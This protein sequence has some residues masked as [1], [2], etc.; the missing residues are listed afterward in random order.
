MNR[1]QP[2]ADHNTERLTAACVLSSVGGML[3]IYTYL[4][5]GKV[6]ANAVTGNMVLFGFHL[7]HQEW[8]YSSKY[9]L[10]IMS[11]ALGIFTAELLHLKVP[12]SRKISWHQSVI[13]LELCLLLLV[14]FIPYGEWDFAVNALISF[15]CAL[16]VQTF[17]RVRGFPFASTMCTGNLRSG[18]DALFRAWQERNRQEWHKA[19]HYYVVIV[20][21]IAGAT[22][23]AI[24]LHHYG[25]PVFLL[26]PLGLAAV[27]FL[28]AP[29]RH[30]R[31]HYH[32]HHH[33][34]SRPPR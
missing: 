29:I 4:C 14:Y 2:T 11:Y 16:Q 1:P 17:R 7:A 24:L 22:T 6:F 8:A 27:F 30:H 15:V 13:L 21:F 20:C 33:R 12:A 3:D 31:I 23:G 9:L 18:T 5:R 25:K 26:A 32:R 28:I 10:A 19:L 34:V